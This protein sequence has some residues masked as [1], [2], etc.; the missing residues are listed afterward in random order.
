MN[1]KAKLVNK[2]E[3]LL[4]DE[5]YSQ[6][7]QLFEVK[8]AELAE[9]AKDW[10]ARKAIQE[11]INRTMMELK[12]KKLPEVLRHAE[13]L[14]KELTGGKYTALIV[15]ESGAFEALS[16]NGIRY[17]I[18]EL[19]QATKEQAY[20][21]LRLAL[22]ASILDSAPFPIIMDDPFVHFDGERLSRMMKLM[23]DSQGHQ[24][25]Y[26]TCHEKMKKYWVDGTIVNVSEIG[27]EKGALFSETVT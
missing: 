15:P 14:F 1:E 2:T 22:A 17:P 21:S 4:T 10:S 13:Q 8:K 19:S 12:E 16:E 7:R 24:F 6:L 20:I 23:K 3:Q 26:F 5:T 27:N 18:I 9:L 11:G 25:I